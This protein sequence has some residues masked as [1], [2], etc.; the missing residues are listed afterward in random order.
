M[1]VSGYYHDHPDPVVPVWWRVDEITPS[2]EQ[3]IA[4][5]LDVA[6]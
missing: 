3:A 5:Y 4:Q 6:R 1:G 2:V